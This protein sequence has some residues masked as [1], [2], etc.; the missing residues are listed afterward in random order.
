MMTKICRKFLST[1][2]TIAFMNH[3]AY[4]EPMDTVAAEKLP[5]L[6]S[7][8]QSIRIG[9]ALSS[10]EV[11]KLRECLR[12]GDPVLVSI[13]SWCV[14][15]LGPQGDILQPAISE[16]PEKLGDM[17]D[18]FVTL[19]KEGKS[20]R[21]L[22]LNQRKERLEKLAATENPYLKVE[23]AKRLLQ[24]DKVAGRELLTRLAEAPA[25]A[26]AATEAS[27]EL[28]KLDKS[29]GKNTVEPLPY[30]DERYET[31]LSIIE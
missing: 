5:Q 18:A 14:F 20:A 17:P 8:V 25:K 15:K 12:S 11:E 6:K 19:A 21:Q 27:R 4:A 30:T 28:R 9:N 31:V 1:I 22:D 10:T 13:A 26:Q 16:V 24:I 3:H 7:L 29:E 23:A 2:I